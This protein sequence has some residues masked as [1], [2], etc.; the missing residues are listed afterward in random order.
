MLF[1]LIRNSVTNCFDFR[2]CCICCGLATTT[3]WY[4]VEVVR[5]KA[6][7]IFQS[8][9]PE[10]WRVKPII[11][12]HVPIVIALKPVQSYGLIARAEGEVYVP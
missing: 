3:K 11:T 4:A 5:N 9:R 6:R 8:G 7:N 10:A 2:I 1:L 12:N